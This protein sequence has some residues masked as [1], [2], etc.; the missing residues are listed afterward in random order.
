MLK[1]FSAHPMAHV[2][3][4]TVERAAEIKTLYERGEFT[5]KE[6]GAMFGVH[7]SQISRILSKRSLLSARATQL[8]VSRKMPSGRTSLRTLRAAM[9]SA[10]WWTPRRSRSSRYSCPRI[11]AWAVSGE[12]VAATGG[13]R[14]VGI[15]LSSD[16]HASIVLC[17]VESGPAL[18]VIWNLF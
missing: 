2:P 9:P 16:P 1:W 7:Q 14:A 11:R 4:I 6:L 17:K 12:L 10:A 5:Q 18:G 3:D 15:L 13:G 8:S